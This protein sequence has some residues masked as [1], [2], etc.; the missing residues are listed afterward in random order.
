MLYLAFQI[1]SQSIVGSVASPSMKL[2]SDFGEKL[3]NKNTD[4]CSPFLCKHIFS[5]QFS[6]NVRSFCLL[7]HFQLFDSSPV[8]GWL[9]MFFN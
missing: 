8:F 2:L 1:N 5:Y 3:L 9:F 6:F 7:I 4:S